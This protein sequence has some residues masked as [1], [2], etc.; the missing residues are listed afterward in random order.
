LK[1]DQMDT[2]LESAR[3]FIQSAS[4]AS[5]AATGSAPPAGSRGGAAAGPVSPSSQGKSHVSL[6]TT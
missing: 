3:R 2:M 1:I 6:P 5:G 4:A